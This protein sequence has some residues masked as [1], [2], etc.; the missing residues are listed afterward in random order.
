[1]CGRTTRATRTRLRTFAGARAP[2]G[3]VAF[4]RAGLDVVFHA[5]ARMPNALST[6]AF[7][8]LGDRAAADH[9]Q[10]FVLQNVRIIRAARVL[11]LPLTPPSHSGSSSRLYGSLAPRAS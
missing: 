1:R 11:E 7:G 3:G 10:R 2:R 5:F 6:L 4:C 8:D 9:R